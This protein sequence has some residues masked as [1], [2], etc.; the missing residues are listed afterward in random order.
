MIVD[1]VLT[2][3]DESDTTVATQLSTIN[4]NLLALRHYYYTSTIR[5]KVEKLSSLDGSMERRVMVSL[6]HLKKVK[7]CFFILFYLMAT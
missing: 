7:L 1:G 2:T 3:F 5:K 6:P 4:S